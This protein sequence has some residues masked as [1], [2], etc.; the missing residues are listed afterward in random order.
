M[1]EG[2]RS[3]SLSLT[4][5]SGSRRPKDPQHWIN[6]YSYNVFGTLRD[7][8]VSMSPSLMAGQR[9]SGT[10]IREHAE[11]FW[12][13]ATAKNFGQQHR[14]RGNRRSGRRRCC[15]VSIRCAGQN[16]L[17]LLHFKSTNTPVYFP[18]WHH[19]GRRQCR[20]LIFRSPQESILQHH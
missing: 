18:A 4:S 12:P 7:F 19:Q 10:Y 20:F 14:K 8:L 6:D 11:H 9:D 1:I 17:N 2:P 16:I 13:C 15:V 5:G 3:R